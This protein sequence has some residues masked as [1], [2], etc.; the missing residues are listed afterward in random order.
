MGQPQDIRENWA[1]FLDLDGTL[2]DI[3]EKPDLVT[4]PAGL[5]G[6]LARLS[7]GLCGAL[8]VVSGR[9]MSVLDDLLSP[10]AGPGAAEHG[11]VVRHVGGELDAVKSNAI[12]AIW[13]HT[14]NRAAEAWKGIVIERKPRSVVVHYRLAPERA[15][16][17]KALVEGLPDLDREGFAV[18]AAKMAFEVK[19]KSSSK[20]RAV[21][22]LMEEAPFAGRIP[23]FVGDDQTDEAGIDMAQRLGGFGLRVGTVF[24]N[25]PAAVRA[26]IARG[27][28]A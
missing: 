25:D 5:P 1:L 15:A 27:V 18:M 9:A 11:A 7:R 26:W 13:L 2:L 6:D 4:V 19:P 24:G 16:D 22:L 17:V 10:F 3:A 20:G 28:A 23:V 21:A 14:L 8:A 12:P